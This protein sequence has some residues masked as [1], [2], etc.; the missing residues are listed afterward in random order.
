MKIPFFNKGRE[1][2]GRKPSDDPNATILKRFSNFARPSASYAEAL[3]AQAAMHHIVAYRCL[4]KIATTF[5]GIT[6]YIERD[7]NVA[8]SFRTSDRKI[9]QLQEV[10]INPNNNM[11]G[12]QLQYWIS[13][14]WALYGRIPLKV[15]VSSAEARPN[16]IYP[17]N[18]GLT[19]ELVNRAGEIY[20][21]RYGKGTDAVE[22][23]AMR[24]VQRTTRGS[25]DERGEFPSV[26]FAHEIVRPNIHGV[27]GVRNNNNSALKAIGLPAS[28]IT[29]LLQRAHDTASGHP[30]SKYIV[31]TEKT[32][33]E[34]QKGELRNQFEG[35]EV[36]EEES[37]NVLILGNT[38]VQV[39]KLDNNLSDIHSKM[40][41]D[42]MSR[43]V[44]GAFG[45]PI[46]LLGFAGADGSKFA[47]NY[48]ES[49]LSFYEDTI[50]PGYCEP[51]ARGLTEIM[52]P[53]GYV[54]KADLDTIPALQDRRAKR[55]K[56]L[57]SISFLSIDEKRELCGYGPYKDSGTPGGKLPQPRNTTP[58]QDPP[59]NPEG[60]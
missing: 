4:D 43:H 32:L 30:N 28:V 3:E 7:P 59:T 6:F 42:D 5:Q 52:C 50:V 1:I 21:Y 16:G 44:A 55:A 35:R 18:P 45:V 34:P 58:V 56:D 15:G 38:K 24:K 8:K 57:E 19:E 41:L 51:I 14:V 46:A 9:S 53:E 26:A 49:R 11:N 20:A 22:I 29:L 40:P 36:G 10:L 27:T 33:T 54:V 25:N 37:G 60:E 2:G 31:A 12:A 23:P 39:E 48:E 47:N 13:L 17:L